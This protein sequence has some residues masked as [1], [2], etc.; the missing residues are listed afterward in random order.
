MGIFNIAAS[1]LSVISG[2][3]TIYFTINGLINTALIFFLM[4]I[5]F[6]IFSTL[7]LKN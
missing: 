5:L 3:G 2:G 6:Q 1:I 4:M 7:P